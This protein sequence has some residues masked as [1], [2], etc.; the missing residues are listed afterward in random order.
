M[1]KSIISMLCVFTLLVVGAIFECN[2]ILRQFKEF[3]V[4]LDELYVKIDEKTAVKEDVIAVQD[5]WIEKKKWL[6]VFIPHN[7]IKEVDL[8]IAESVVLVRD[9]KWGDA[10]SKVEVLKELSEQIPKTFVVS[11]ENIL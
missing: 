6:H 9:K 4:V 7:E 2:F 1:V 10:L 3:D 5:N 8:W 11:I